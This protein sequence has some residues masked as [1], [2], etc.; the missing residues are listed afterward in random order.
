LA[1]KVDKGEGRSFDTRDDLPQC[2]TEAHTSFKVETKNGHKVT[3]RAFYEQVHFK[4]GEKR[5]VI[6]KIEKINSNPYAKSQHVIATPQSKIVNHIT[7]HVNGNITLTFNNFDR[8]TLKPDKNF[9]IEKFLNLIDR[10][11]KFFN[12]PK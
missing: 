11:Y 2:S 3:S 9:D 8:V 4:S 5:L 6:T 1:K 12:G 10:S 7:R